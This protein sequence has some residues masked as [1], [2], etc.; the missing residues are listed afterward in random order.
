VAAWHA[1]RQRLEGRRSARRLPLPDASAHRSPAGPSGRHRGP[2]RYP[3][4]PTPVTPIVWL[5][6]SPTGTA[7]TLR[8]VGSPGHRSNF[9]IARIRQSGSAVSLVVRCESAASGRYVA[10]C[11]SPAMSPAALPLPSRRLGRVCFGRPRPVAGRPADRQQLRARDCSWRGALRPC[12]RSAAPPC[13]TP[14]ALVDFAR[15]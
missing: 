8:V 10:R 12:V 11:R 5:L 14:S 4:T 9:R 13:L 15:A 2:A 7:A 6:S 3:S 1:K